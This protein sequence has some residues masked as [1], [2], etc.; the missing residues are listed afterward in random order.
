[1]RAGVH[2]HRA[3]ERRGDRDAELEAGEP[4]A[5]GDARRAPAAAST[6]PAVSRRPSR[7]LHR[8]LLPEPQHEPGEPLVGDEHVR[9]LPE[10][11]ERDARLDDRPARRRE[12]VLGLRLE[13]QRRGPPDPE[14]RERRQREVGPDPVA[15]ARR[16]G[17]PRRAAEIAGHPAS[18]IRSS[19]SSP[20]IHTSPHP[21]VRTRSPARTSRSRN[22]ATSGRCGQVD[23][24]GPAGRLGDAVHDELAR[25]PGDRLLRGAVH[26]GHD[27]DV[28]LGEARAQLPPERL[29]P[30]V[31]V[32]LEDR[33]EP[34]GSGAA[35]DAERDRELRRDVAVVVVELRAASRA[36]VL[37]PA[38]HPLEGGERLGGRDRPA[39]PRAR[40]R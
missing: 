36:P 6:P 7:A 14:R 24:A 29:R 25:H 23:D 9:S 2:P 26:V 22:R 31:P 39:R 20:S 8:K 12:V 34:P 35:G 27:H 15:A 30:R 38:P 13:V 37:E 4:V 19:A 33:D 18:R 1:M 40:R 28:G 3:A 21:I 17:S 5:Q 16:G 11:D 32:R 10:D